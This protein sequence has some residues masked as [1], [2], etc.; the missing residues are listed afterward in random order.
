MDGEQFIP[1]LDPQGGFINLDQIPRHYDAVGP[2][3]RGLLDRAHEAALAVD[4]HYTVAQVKQKFGS[5][6]LY[7]NGPAGAQA[8]V[9]P[10]ERE[11]AT[12]C[13]ECAESAQL[14]KIGMWYT[15]L[16]PQ[17]E[18]AERGEHAARWGLDED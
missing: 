13:E 4:P 16:C 10:F 12:V 15:T 8:V 7:L 5:L 14:V 11:S 9:E 18:S 1:G 3:W 6:R 2:G 17:H